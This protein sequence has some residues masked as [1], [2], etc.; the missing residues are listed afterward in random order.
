MTK[1]LYSKLL[2]RKEWKLK[3]IVILERDSHI[4]Q[5]CGKQGGSLHV[6][7][8]LYINGKMPWEYSDNHLITLCGPC[9]MHEHKTTKI[10]VIGSKPKKPKKVKQKKKPRT[11]EQRLKNIERLKTMNDIKAQERK[12]REEL[13]LSLIPEWRRVKK[14]N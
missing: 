6:H 7:H 8:K 4:C 12:E 9:H 10:P 5:K 2:R 11:R 13:R 14:L 3:R 1:E